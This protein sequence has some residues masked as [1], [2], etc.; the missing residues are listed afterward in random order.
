M[1]EDGSKARGMSREKKIRFA[2][3]MEF[4]FNQFS[5]TLE[6]SGIKAFCCLVAFPVPF[7]RFR[8]IL[9][10]AVSTFA[11]HDGIRINLISYLGPCHP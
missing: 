11:E 7:R 3:Q 5:F 10:G 9:F 4:D 2:F 8:F 6:R 1:T